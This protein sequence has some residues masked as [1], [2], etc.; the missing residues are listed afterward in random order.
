VALKILPDSAL[1]DAR[2]IR[3]FQREAMAAARL[4]HTNIVPVFGVGQQDGYP[5]YVMQYIEGSGLDV[6]F[7]ELRR[8]RQSGS[9]PHTQ[10]AHSHADAAYGTK[11]K[12]ASGDGEH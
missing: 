8:L 11:T 3:R 12:P 10:R 2:Q 6:V 4:H 5:Y 9:R 1:H 7:G